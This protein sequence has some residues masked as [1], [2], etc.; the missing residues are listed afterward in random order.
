[1]LCRTA[2]DLYWL[3]RYVER[4]ENIARLVDLTQRISLLPE[5]L[6]PGKSATTAWRRGLDALGQLELFGAARGEIEPETVR[7]WLMLDAD[8]PSSIH[9]CLFHGRELGRAQRGAITAEMYQELNT[10]WLDLAEA[11]EGAADS[12]GVS[13]FLEWVKTR[14]AA[15]R[16]VTFG[17]MG[18]DEGYHFM[19]LGTAVERADNTVRLLD[20]KYAQSEEHESSS[21]DFIQYYQWSAMLQ[22]MSAFETYRKNYRDAVDPLH[23]SEMMIFQPDMPHSLT[24]CTQSIYR[25]LEVLAQDPRSEV[26]RKSGALAARLRYGCMSEVLDQ[27]IK[28]FLDDF[29]Q[30]LHGLTQ[31]IVD[32]FMT[33]T[34]TGNAGSVEPGRNTGAVVS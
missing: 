15:F 28:A 18:R 25:I 5:R 27:G 7:Q 23:V 31:A 12:D 8:N 6:D 4:A 20:I 14:S 9:N 13:A 29:M 11:G 22:S 17:T 30:Q 1:M 26:V 19:A 3:S 21:R 33:S 32:A 24:A 2:S 34:A 10:S 16:G